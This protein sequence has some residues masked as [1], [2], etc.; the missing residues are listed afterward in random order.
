MFLKNAFQLRSKLL[1]FWFMPFTLL[2]AQKDI[3]F[4]IYFAYLLLV[5]SLTSRLLFRSGKNTWF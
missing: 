5:A 1:G 4:N 3:S 2:F